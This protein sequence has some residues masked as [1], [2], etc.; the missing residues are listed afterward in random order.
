MK[1]SQSQLIADVNLLHIQKRITEAERLRQIF[2]IVE[3]YENK[4]ENILSEQ[5]PK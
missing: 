1:K 4:V 3:K 2:A 5:L